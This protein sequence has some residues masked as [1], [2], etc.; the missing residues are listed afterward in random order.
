MFGRKPDG[1]KDP[2]MP[3]VLS[4]EKFT[5]DV[6]KTKE[7]ESLL[8]K[9]LKSYTEQ[10]AREPYLIYIRADRRTAKIYGVLLAQR[11][12]KMQAHMVLVPLQFR[13]NGYSTP[14]YLATT[15]PNVLIHIEAADIIRTN[16]KPFDEMLAELVLYYDVLS[17]KT[18][19]MA[20]LNRLCISGEYE[21]KDFKLL[22]EWTWYIDAKK[23]PVVFDEAEAVRAGRRDEESY[24]TGKI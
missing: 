4:D 14:I 17:D 15:K 21:I 7:L 18:Y 19:G 10:Y 16:Q 3:R 12:L 6:K 23:A 24:G 5:V 2:F 9:E 22:P 8:Q 11:I 1:N 20:P 13:E